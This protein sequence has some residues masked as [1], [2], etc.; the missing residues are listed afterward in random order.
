[1]IQG[2]YTAASGMVAHQ[3]RLD[4]LANNLANVDTTGFKAD[5]LALDVSVTPQDSMSDS[6]LPMSSVLADRPGVDPRPGP[7]K[8]TG[9]PLDL[10]IVGPGLFVVETPQG[11]RYTRAGDF[12]QDAEGYLT[13]HGGLR[14]LGSGGPIA[15]PGTGL[16]IDE[17]G[18]LATGETLRVVAG[19]ERA[20]LVKVGDNLFASEEGAARP[21][22]LAGAKIVQG[23]VEGSNVNV[24][25]TMVEML[26]TMRSYEAYQKTIQALD[27]TV[28]QA[29]NDLGRV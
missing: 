3:V 9:N 26:A 23:Q 14:V 2:L 10:A 15:V 19:P 24:V 29:A 13:T 1:M 4:M 12:A 28:G 5:L 6:S 22:D 20:R 27:Q 17:T 11:E 16:Q 21:E 8:A 7:L 25:M 18:R